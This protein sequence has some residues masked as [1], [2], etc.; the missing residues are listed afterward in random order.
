[1]PSLACISQCLANNAKAKSI[2]QLCTQTAYKIIVQ[3]LYFPLRYAVQYISHLKHGVLEHLKCV[4]SKSRE[5]VCEIA[6]KM[7]A[8]LKHIKAKYLSNNFVLTMT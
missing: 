3:C 2:C 4:R 8:F 7:S 1:M 6:D 5:V